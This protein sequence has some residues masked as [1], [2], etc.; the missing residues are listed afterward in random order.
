MTWQNALK[1]R[2]K[3]ENLKA[4]GSLY[5]FLS[6]LFWNYVIIETKI[7]LEG[8]KVWSGK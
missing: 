2:I 8:E 1:P 5:R 6:F 3:A 7:K 4:K